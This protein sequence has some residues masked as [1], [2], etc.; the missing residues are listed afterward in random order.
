[1]FI[2]LYL[3]E[4]ETFRNLKTWFLHT[5]KLC[6]NVT[7]LDVLL[8][9]PNH[10]DSTEIDIRNFVI[11]FAKCYIYSCKRNTIAVYLYSFQVKLKTGMVVEGYRCNMYM[12]IV[13]FSCIKIT[14]ENSTTCDSRINLFY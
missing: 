12:K 3:S 14:I 1:M 8:G 5:F 11:L 13:Q 2:C 10:S 7:P 4:I 6:I 9:I